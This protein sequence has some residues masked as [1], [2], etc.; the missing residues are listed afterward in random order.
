[1]TNSIQ[2]GSTGTPLPGGIIV[3][4]LSRLSKDFLES[5]QPSESAFILSTDDENSELKA[6]SVWAKDL[7]PA[8]KARELMGEKRAAYRLILHLNVDEVRA[9]RISKDF[10]VTPLEVVWDTDSRPGAEGHAG[11]TGLLRPPSGERKLYKAL[12][13]KL[14]QIV[15]KI[16]LLP[17]IPL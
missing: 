6:L 1:M 5:Q 15:T 4:R 8:E 3:L 7:T 2:P 12:R 10:P 13:V 16:E 9:I 14:T 11:I 17:E